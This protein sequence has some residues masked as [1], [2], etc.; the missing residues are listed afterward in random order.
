MKIKIVAWGGH[1]DLRPYVSLALGLKRAGHI[2]DLATLASEKEFVTSFG[3]NCIPMEWNTEYR[4]CL[5]YPPFSTIVWHSDEVRSLEDGL[6]PELWRV[7]Q[8][9]EAIIFNGPSYPCVYIAEK[10]GIPCFAAPVQPHHQTRA[11]PHPFVTNGKPLGKIY[12]W[13]SYAFFDQ[14]FWQYVRQPINQWRQEVLNLPPLSFTEGITKRMQRQKIPFLYGYS[15]AF[16]PKPLDWN[17]DLIHVTGY[18]FLDSSENWQPPHEL[19]NFL[20]AGTPPIYISKIWHKKK[21][22]KDLVKEIAN[23]TGQRI[24]VQGL[25]DDIDSTESTDNV[26]YIKGRIPHEWLF[27]KMAA[28]VHHGGCGTIMSCLRAGVPMIITP[29][30]VPADHYFWG[31]EVSNS[32]LG[33]CVFPRQEEI[34]AQNLADA[35][36]TVINDQNMQAK[37]TN[38]SHQ[39]QKENGVERAV[40][41][42][43]QY[44]SSV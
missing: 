39:I 1:G 43:N 31:V 23:L 3:V 34:S 32:G 27:P 41:I 17:D 30:R 20:S 12:N 40:D 36:K 26:F 42:L 6:L 16:L 5:E 14:L 18:W 2:V 15:P 8:N 13:L 35:I 10:L 24:V 29:F 25:S 4:E 19:I 9:A 33:I 28:V 37:L 11:F 44:L 7:C 38:I 22:G 21:L